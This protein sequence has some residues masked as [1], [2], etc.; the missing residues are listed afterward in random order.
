MNRKT[1]A[2]AGGAILIALALV[3]I[4]YGLWFEDLNLTGQM[5]T[6]V[7]DVGIINARVKE[8][9]ADENDEL[10]AMQGTPLF[11]T[12]HDGITSCTVALHGPDGLDSPDPGVDTGKDELEITVTGAYPSYHCL[13][14]FEVKNLGTVPVHLIGPVSDPAN[15]EGLT[16]LEACFREGKI[17]PPHVPISGEPWY[18]GETCSPTKGSPDDPRN[19]LDGV[20]TLDPVTETWTGH[21]T[22]SSTNCAYLIGLTTY[23]RVDPSNILET[24]WLYDYDTA[25]IEPGQSLD[26]VVEDAH[27]A[28]Q[29]DLF[30]GPVLWTLTQNNQY[31]RGLPGY[32]NNVDR[33][34]DYEHT[35]GND[36]CE[37]KWQLHYPYSVPCSIMVHFTNADPIEEGQTYTF[38][39]A[40]RAYQWNEDDAVPDDWNPFAGLLGE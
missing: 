10:V 6:G 39:Y 3:G 2:A 32:W 20:M 34:L 35:N 16:E 12:K 30:W 8:W 15:P 25:V 24:Q 7:L 28:G 29:T 13:V 23:Q 21:V 31:Y 19:A 17:P 4:G 40:I 36:F 27:C 1:L 14:T 26:L 22:N 18:F 38:R 5:T 33:K 9:Y 11:R 37:P